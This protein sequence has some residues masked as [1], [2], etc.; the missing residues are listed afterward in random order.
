MVAFGLFHQ[1]RVGEPGLEQRAGLHIAVRLAFAVAPAGARA[2]GV[3]PVSAVSRIR[4]VWTCRRY[5]GAN[6]QVS[7]R[8]PGGGSL[9]GE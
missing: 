8:R 1:H 4:A 9:P 7:A 2:G 5:S 6:G 3:A